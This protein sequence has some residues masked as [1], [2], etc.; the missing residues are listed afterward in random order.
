MIEQKKKKIKF[1]FHMMKKQA[2]KLIWSSA[3]Y[4][5]TF[6]L[7]QTLIFCIL[8]FNFHS[9]ANNLILCLLSFNSESITNTLIFCLLSI[10]FHS[11]TNTLIFCLLSINFHSITKTQHHFSTLYTFNKIWNNKTFNHTKQLYIYNIFILS[12]ANYCQAYTDFKMILKL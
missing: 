1:Y 11:A 5:L 3:F 2:W 12:H 6:T 4:L 8:S 7:A 9:I 10:N